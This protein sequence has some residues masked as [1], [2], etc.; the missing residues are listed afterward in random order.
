LPAQ[1]VIILEMI[2]QSKAGAP[3]L[4]AQVPGFCHDIGCFP[5]LGLQQENAGRADDNMIDLAVFDILVILLP[6]YCLLE[7]QVDIVDD[8]IA[9]G[10]RG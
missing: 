1:P 3:D 10:Q 5:V 7:M 8:V 4:A 2:P 6:V 9:L